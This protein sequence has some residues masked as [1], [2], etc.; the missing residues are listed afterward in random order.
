V[1]VG[2]LKRLGGDSVDPAVDDARVIDA[3]RRLDAVYDDKSN[4][5]ALWS[6]KATFHWS[7]TF[8]AGK[9][10]VV[11]HRYRPVYGNYY[12]QN[13]DPRTRITKN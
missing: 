5:F 10:L 6:T 2:D 9:R 3:L 12:I 13:D 8:P 1:T 4:T 7:Q 11:R